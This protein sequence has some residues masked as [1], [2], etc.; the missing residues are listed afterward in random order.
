MKTTIQF[1][2]AVLQILCAK[3]TYGNVMKDKS[4]VTISI[5]LAKELFY[6]LNLPVYEEEN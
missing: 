4:L 2:E 6:Q 5:A 3:E 1:N